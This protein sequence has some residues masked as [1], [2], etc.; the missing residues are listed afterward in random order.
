MKKIVRYFL[1]IAFVSMF[2]LVGAIG[3]INNASA[4][5]IHQDLEG[6]SIITSNMD[7]VRVAV[8]RPWTAAEMAAAVPYPIPDYE[9]TG[10]EIQ[11]DALGGPDG[12]AGMEPGSTP[13]GSQSNTVAAPE[14]ELMMGGVDFLGYSYPPP[15]T[16]HFVHTVSNPNVYPFR[17]VGKL[18]FK[19]FG[20]SYVCSAS[21]IGMKGLA[22]AG[23]CVHAGN[24]SSTGWSTNVIFVPAYANGSA[25]YQQWAAASLSTI[26]SWYQSA[27]V[28]YDV[29]GIR[30]IA[31]G[32]VSIGTR[33][34]G[35]LGYAWNQPRTLS[36]WLLGYPQA[37]PFDGKWMVACQSSY[38][39]DSP[40]GTAGPAPMGV[41]CD[42]TGG[43]SGGPWIWQFASGNL[44]N[45][46]N[47]HRTS[48]KPYELFSPYIDSVNVTIFDWARNW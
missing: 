20:T 24:N 39:Y 12:P 18:F 36:W 21:V 46:V 8:T 31:N 15:F 35:Y 7:L 40:F 38:A 25:P 3:P 44:V 48:N 32:G 27:N 5:P 1:S 45:G 28:R 11:V 33:I 22:T 34:G 47:S 4:S 26:Y 41:G 19:Q 16:R 6:G 37:A 42:Q 43:T 29:G 30:T 10:A 14:V 2:L 9:S 23:H 17:T 13:G